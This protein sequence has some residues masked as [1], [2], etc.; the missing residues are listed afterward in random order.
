MA[1]VVGVPAEYIPMMIRIWRGLRD[2]RPLPTD[3]WSIDA[4]I[5]VAVGSAGEPLMRAGAEA[6]AAILPNLTVPT[7]EGHD[8][9]ASW[10]APDAIAEQ[11]RA[12]LRAT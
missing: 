11:I 7:P 12:F 3:R 6:L 9:G 10:S 4:P 8:P 2:G 5:A 1:E